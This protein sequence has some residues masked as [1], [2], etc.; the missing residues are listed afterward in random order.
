MIARPLK[1]ITFDEAILQQMKYLF[2]AI[3]AKENCSCLLGW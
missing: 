1:K 2:F 3:F